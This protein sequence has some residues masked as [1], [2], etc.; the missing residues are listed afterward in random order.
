MNLD[1][2]NAIRSRIERAF[3][4]VQDLS[5]VGYQTSFE[6]NDT[7][8]TT[9]FQA[10]GV[11]N[12]EQLQDDFLILFIWIWSFKDYLKSALE[13]K[14]L[15]GKIV[16]DEVNKCPALTYVADIANRAKHGT[17][18]KSRSGQDAKLM[19]I[20]YEVPQESIGNISIAGSDVSLDIISP[21]LIQIRARVVTSSGTNLEALTVLSDAMS[22][23]ETQV[24]P[25][26]A[27][28]PS[29]K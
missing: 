27:T 24:L 7:N 11:K 6:N 3:D 1:D 29:F 21:K 13:A 12:P 14:G 18:S 23:W 22:F 17:L 15:C 10:T 20:G 16:E 26:I 5:G 28:Y 4:T 9:N 25:R 2:L 8:F 19:E